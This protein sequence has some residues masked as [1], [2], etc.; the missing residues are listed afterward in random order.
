MTATLEHT[1]GQGKPEVIPH[2]VSQSSKGESE[3]KIST[4]QSNIDLLLTNKN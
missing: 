3:N 2:L 4:V 1:A